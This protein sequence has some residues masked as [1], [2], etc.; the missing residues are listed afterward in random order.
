[1]KPVRID[2]EVLMQYQIRIIYRLAEFADADSA[3]NSPL[4]KHEAPFYCLECVPMFIAMVIWNVWHPGRY[5]VGEDSEFPKKVK[6]SRKDKALMKQ[7][8]KAAEDEDKGNRRRN[9]NRSSR[10]KETQTSEYQLTPSN[11]GAMEE[12]YAHGYRT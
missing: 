3:G 12:G 2:S 1:M 5:I 10:R 9:R 6:L 11:E 7:Q 8:A 4:S